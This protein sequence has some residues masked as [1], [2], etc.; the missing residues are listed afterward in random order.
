M[1]TIAIL[2]GDDIGREVVP[3]C[4]KVMRAAAAAVD[5]AIDWKP[6]PI[7]RAGHAAAGHTVPA[8]TL[9]TLATYDGWILGPIGHR[10]YPKGDP[11]WLNPHPLFRTHFGLFANYKPFRSY[12]NLPSLHKDIDLL[13]LRETTEGFKVDGNLFM[14]YGEF[15]PTEDS[16]IGICVTTKL[17][18]RLIAEAAFEAARQRPRRKVTAVHKNT[19]YRYGDGLFADECRKVAALHPDVEFEEVIVD[20]FA[21]RLVMKP[22]QYDTIVTTNLYGDILTDEAAGLVGGL[23][24]APGLNASE[25][26][27]MAQATHG[28]APDIA[29]RGIANPYAMIM[30]GKLLFDWLAVKRGEPKAAQAAGLIERAMTQVIAGARHLTPDLGGSASTQAMGDAVAQAI[31]PPG[32]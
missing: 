28:S 6:M 27:A 8:G 32:R 20:T 1:L 16:A 4:V 10:E 31:A 19:V 3:E 14:G 12:P 24:L 22:Q 7:S 5:L 25:T 30:S 23:G 18:S 9:E 15:M 26:L 21:M 2:E 29:G 17:K 13:F 11:S